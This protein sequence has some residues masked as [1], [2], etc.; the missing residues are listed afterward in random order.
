L[1][2]YCDIIRKYPLVSIGC[3]SAPFKETRKLIGEAFD[4]IADNNVK[5]GLSNLL[6]IGTNTITKPPAALS[7]F[8]KTKLKIDNLKA[9][10]KIIPY[11]ILA[12]TIPITVAAMVV[13]VAG[14]STIAPPF[15]VAASL[16]GVARS[17]GTF[18]SDKRSL[19]NLNKQ[20]ITEDKIFKKIDNAKLS[21][22]DKHILKKSIVLPQEIYKGLYELRQHVIENTQLTTKE[23]NNLIKE[24]NE[25][26]EE[27]HDKG[28]S[29][30]SL[31]ASGSAE[32]S[33]TQLLAHINVKIE[34]LNKVKKHLS[35][36]DFKISSKL[37]KQIDYHKNT[38]EHIYAQD[39]PLITK[40]KMLSLLKE[41][42]MERSD[43]KEIY[44]QMVNHSINLHSEVQKQALDKAV[45]NYI[46][47][48]SKELKNDLSKEQLMILKEHLILPRLIYNQLK[49]M[50]DTLP[51]DK[52]ESF[53][54]EIFSEMEKS[55]DFDFLSKVNKFIDKE[56][57]MSQDLN[58]I[59]TKDVR[60]K[61][62]VTEMDLPEADKSLLDRHRHGM[63]IASIQTGGLDV[64]SPKV[65]NKLFL[66][67][68]EIKE[69]RIGKYLHEKIGKSAS[70]KVDIAVKLISDP[71]KKMVQKGKF[72]A[73]KQWYGEDKAKEI[74]LEK[75]NI[76][77]AK[78]EFRAQFGD[79]H[80]FM[81][82]AE[83][84][85]FLKHAVK[86]DVLNIGLS[87][88]SL[89]VTVAGTA[90]TLAAVA[91][92]PAA[93]GVAVAFGAATTVVA[94]TAMANTGILA[95]QNYQSMAKAT[96]ANKIAESVTKPTVKSE[97]IQ[98]N[99]TVEHAENKQQRKEKKIVKKEVSQRW[100][101]KPNKD[102]KSN[103]HP[104][105]KP[106]L[107]SYRHMQAQQVEKHTTVQDANTTNAEKTTVG[108]IKSR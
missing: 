42:K 40:D 28:T 6:K 81:Q 88:T 11:A 27:F 53:R 91:G 87:V 92:G 38:H 78:S 102:A 103:S 96:D 60:R 22:K 106:L 23:K 21:D 83:E 62:E 7:S 49:E 17:I 95:I 54:K 34:D 2:T 44:A 33:I 56:S 46:K 55:P 107:S 67:P 105:S 32:S 41:S 3:M 29:T 61:K 71:F 24:I 64:P 66:T 13:A 65:D 36:P 77:A 35:Q 4:N 108:K 16:A 48:H 20:L 30:I 50:H 45:V 5:D 63:M 39:L 82:H 58:A 14:L 9:T 12:V 10:Q 68:P 93:V 1:L 84:R 19:D 85:N 74:M 15:M 72:S 8:I 97:M 76:K 31:K 89:G 37:R 94:S 98:R 43:H 75:E 80:T 101:T 100:D 47:S 25:K 59:V 90:V 70:E 73:M 99:R 86:R 51:K 69:S 26:I 18:I 79:A 57:P 52:R 104:E